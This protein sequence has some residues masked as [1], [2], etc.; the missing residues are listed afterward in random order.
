MS[1]DTTDLVTPRILVVDDERQ[2]HASL[3]LRLAKQYDL[4]CCFNAQAALQAL[5]S[6]R[7]DLCLVDIHMPEMD[8]LA[9]IEAAQRADPALGYVVLS[10][11]DSSENLRR[12]IPLHVFD[13][14]GK[15]LPERDGFE[16]RLPEWIDRTR[17]QRRDQ[18]LARQAGAI[19]HDLGLARLEREVELVASETAR[20]AL[21]QTANLL[22]TIHA[23]LVSAAATVAPRA[24]TEASA[25]Q[26]WRNLEEARK[27]A[28]AAASVAAGFFDSAYASRDSSPALVDSGIRDAIGIAA[29]IGHADSDNK[30]V[31]FVALESRLPIRGLSGIDFLLLMVPAIGAVLTLAGANTTVGIRGQPLARLDVAVKDPGLRSFLWVNRKHALTSQPGVLISVVT[32]APPL[33]RAQT[34]AWLRGEPGSLAA[35]SPRG[36]IAGIQKSRGLLA[37]SLLPQS[38]QFRLVL[39]LPH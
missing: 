2:I 33:T 1:T 30:A 23:H 11:F 31:D 25:A 29:R 15:P 38:R 37:L 4:V 5:A 34:E 21:L 14:L 7:F 16:A 26:L 27:T 12:A 19:H 36:L 8:G 39:A 22:T 6:E 18:A 28:D 9:F 20:D 10:A 24:R 17:A 13:F 35:V 32:A 3:R